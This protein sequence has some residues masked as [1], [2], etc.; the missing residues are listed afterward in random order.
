[1]KDNLNARAGFGADRRIGQIALDELHRFQAD[2][3]G[4]LAGDE[5]IDAAHRFAALQQ[6][7]GN[8]A[9]DEAGSSGDKI[10]WQSIAPHGCIVTA[11]WGGLSY[12]CHGSDVLLSG[13]ISARPTGAMRRLPMRQERRLNDRSCAR[14]GAVATGDGQ[15]FACC[16]TVTKPY[17]R[18]HDSCSRKSHIGAQAQD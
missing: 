16:P 11:N 15:L 7:R 17:N 8:G 3:I 10:L 1:M 2:Q 18:Q 13:T 4:A 6:G 12:E 9:A 14:D 5:A